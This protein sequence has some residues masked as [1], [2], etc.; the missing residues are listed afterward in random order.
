[1][2]LVNFTIE[3]HT[4]NLKRLGIKEY[5]ELV[6]TYVFYSQPA[7]GKHKITGY[8]EV[9]GEYELCIGSNKFKSNPFR[10]LMLPKPT[11][12]DVINY[13]QYD[14]E[15]AIPVERMMHEDGSHLTK[16]EYGLVLLEILCDELREKFL[17]K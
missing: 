6:G 5:S 10:I 1:M 9:T 17:D 11:I 15:I 13:I 12:E 3:E 7:Y 4:E 16:R 14:A 2:D 8:D